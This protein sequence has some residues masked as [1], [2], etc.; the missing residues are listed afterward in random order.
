MAFYLMGE[1]IDS[2]NIYAQIGEIELYANGV[3][4]PYSVISATSTYQ[5][6]GTAG[7]SDGVTNSVSNMVVFVHT[8]AAHAKFILKCNT[9]F[10][11]VK[12]YGDPQVSY[13]ILRMNY[14]TM[15]SN[16]DPLFTSNAWILTWLAV[17][18]STQ[19]AYSFTHTSAMNMIGKI[20][21]KVT[22]MTVGSF[23]SCDYAAL[24][25]MFGTFSNLGRSTKS[26]ISA[27]SSTPDGKF[28]FIMVGYDNKG[29]RKLVADRNIQTGISW[30]TLNT[31]GLISGNSVKFYKNIT[32]KMTSNTTP[33]PYVIS[34]TNFWSTGYD[35]KY[36]FDGLTGGTYTAFTGSTGTLI[37]D[38]GANNLKKVCKYIYVPIPSGTTR[39]AKSWTFE[40]SNDSVSW[41]IL[42]TRPSE[43][44]WAAG[45]ARG[46]E[47]NN[48]T[49][50][51]Y[52]KLNVTAN[53]GAAETDIDEFLLFE[54]DDIVTVP[55]IRVLTGGGVSAAD[56]DNEWDKIIVE[57]TLNGSI[58]AGDLTTWNWSS[59]QSWVASSDLSSPTYR[60]LRGSGSA[61]N[62]GQT[63][64]SLVGVCGFRPVI[65]VNDPVITTKVLIKALDGSCY[66][67]T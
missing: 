1:V 59:T 67:R 33:A 17:Y 9:P 48:N 15:E 45:E 50:Y 23:I 20:K 18:P 19:S 56:T 35:G 26:E 36:A 60:V 3:K 10:D 61:G 11:S 40:G 34:G 43:I 16:E 58:A 29:R 64:P 31:A 5:N 62:R 41:T 39:N 66:G 53:N 14:Y 6:V 57:S 22:D 63:A 65:I 4:Q 42:D 52:Y 38:F 46:Y 8:A 24:P 27:S 44:N 54:L 28:Y 2:T 51:R 13:T 37:I 32:P 21:T 7:L 12:F 25:N 30:D 49:G 47:F 55:I